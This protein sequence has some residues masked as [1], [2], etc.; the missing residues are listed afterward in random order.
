MHNDWARDYIESVEYTAS[1][2]RA[3]SFEHIR[4]EFYTDN[5]SKES[6]QMSHRSLF[7]LGQ[8]LRGKAGSYKITKQLSEFI[9]FAVYV[10]ALTAVLVSI[11]SNNPP[12][13]GRKSRRG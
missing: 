1:V 6:S 13:P 3:L 10:F 2:S 8:H 9:Y 4:R 11:L 7:Q 12:Q 5:T